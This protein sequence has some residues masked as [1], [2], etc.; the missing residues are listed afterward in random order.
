M[1]RHAISA[2]V[3]RRRLAVGADT[4]VSASSI[5]RLGDIEEIRTLLLNYGR[6]LDDRKLV[7]YSQLFARDG[8]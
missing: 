2:A 5:Q 4:C 1:I 8:E 7:D 3:V 6:L